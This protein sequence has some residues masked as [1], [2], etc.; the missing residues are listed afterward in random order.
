MRTA[1]VWGDALASYRFAPEHPL[2]PRRLELTLSLMRAMHL[3]DGDD[4][5]LA[6]PREASDDE[7]LS[8]HTRAYIEA[9]KRARPNARYGL[10]TEDVP[11]V[12]GMHQAC[13]HVVGATLVAAEQVMSGVAT[14]AFNISGGLHHAQR[15]QASGFCVYN[16]LAIAI[17]WLQKQHGARVLYIDY[18]AHHGDG[19]QSIFYADPEVLTVSLHESGAY[20]FPGTGFVDEIGEG[21]GYGY[22][23]NVPLEPNSGDACVLAAFQ[24]LVPR[25]AAAFAPD[26]IV[27]QN[28]CDAHALDP[29]T[30][31]RCTTWIYQELTRRVCEIADR[32]C[33]GRVIG[34]GGGGYAVYD[35]VPRAWT[36]VWSALRGIDVADEIPREWLEELEREAGRT[37]PATLRDRVDY[38][39]VT[40]YEHENNRK[41]VRAVA[42][43]VMPILTGWGLAF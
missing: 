18:D 2:N 7:L 11:V 43:R 19:V 23:V 5:L 22:S 21:D 4:V 20:L 28:G 16:D 24:E 8:V 42:S 36:L 32:H 33:A 31:L 37:L 15:N 34:T 1:F 12:P 9:V 40:D 6:T 10:G 39:T 29:L 30:H 26:V 25:L 13:A 38:E 14:R 35:V 17:R 3:L 27:L 41:T